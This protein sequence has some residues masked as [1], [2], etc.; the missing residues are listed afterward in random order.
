MIFKN[1]LVANLIM[2]GLT[3]PPLMSSYGHDYEA[4]DGPAPSS[5]FIL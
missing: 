2:F 5:L 3:N 1:M 4:E